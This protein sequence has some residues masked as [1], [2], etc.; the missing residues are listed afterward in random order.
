MNK[1]MTMKTSDI[2]KL[3][4]ARERANKRFDKLPA[5]V[6]RVKIAQDVL[7]LLDVRKLKA[8]HCYFSPDFGLRALPVDY[9]DSTKSLQ[10]MLPKMESCSVC[11]KGALLVAAADLRN[12]VTITQSHTEIYWGDGSVSLSKALGGAFSPEQLGNIEK[13]YENFCNPTSTVPYRL[14][15]YLG[16]SSQ[17]RLRAIMA[18]IIKNKG[19]FRP[20]QEKDA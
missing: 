12:Q 13:A 1:E 17:D 8:A 18:N 16:E 3:A 9:W 6:R 11:A 19:S 14:K 20:S 2:T 10:E 15:S 5:A 7:K 4:A